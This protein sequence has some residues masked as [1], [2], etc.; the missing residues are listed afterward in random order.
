MAMLRP[1]L[2]ALLLTTC[3]VAGPM[4]AGA[5]E[6]PFTDEIE[7]AFA[8]L[9]NLDFQGAHDILNTYIA[10]HGDEA[11][12]YAVSASVDVYHEL[13]R[14]G[15][16]ELEFFADDKRITDKKKLK[17]DPVLRG[18]IFQAISDAQSRAGKTLAAKPDDYHALLAQC[19]T[20]GVIVDYTALVEKRQIGS[21]SIAKR[22][23]GC[24][25]HLL[26]VHPQAYDAYVTT[27]FTEYL[28]GSLPFWVRWFVRFDDVKGSKEQGIRN[29]Q[30]AAQ[31]GHYLKP[32]A[33]VLLALAYL[34]EK[35]YQQ[36]QDL[37]IELDRDNPGNPLFR[38][39][40]ARLDERLHAVSAS[41]P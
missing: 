9:Y 5:A 32:Y 14:L 21:L 4:P 20:E 26:K 12:P 38:N 2:L 23:N 41:A 22:S 36:S 33:K 18:R 35:Q 8:R 28:V 7:R 30:L 27:G 31:S 29:L 16:L 13:D 34:R 24:A 1:G 40:L 17:P 25:Q 19:I 37:L 39:E 10:S 3:V 6:K 15:I 11:L